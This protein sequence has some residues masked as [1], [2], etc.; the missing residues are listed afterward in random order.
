MEKKEIRTF[1]SVSLFFLVAGREEKQKPRIQRMQGSASRKSLF[2]WL[3]HFL[4]LQ[5]GSKSGLTRRERQP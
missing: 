4:N 2:D 3:L 5:K 1:W